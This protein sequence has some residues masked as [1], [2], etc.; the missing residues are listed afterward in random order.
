METAWRPWSNRAT[1]PPAL[2]TVTMLGDPI[3][4]SKRGLIMAETNNN[5]SLPVKKTD[6]G[7]ADGPIDLLDFRKRLDADIQSAGG[8]IAPDPFVEGAIGTTMFDLPGSED[9]TITVLLSQEN[10]H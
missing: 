2:I 6:S 1:S 3:E 9:N 8:E 5:G 4:F 10:A 7:P